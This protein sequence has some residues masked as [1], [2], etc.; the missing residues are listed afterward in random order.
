[1]FLEDIGTV[2]HTVFRQGNSDLMGRV[3]PSSQYCSP[4]SSSLPGRSD[5]HLG[6]PGSR[7][8]DVPLVKLT[9]NTL[10]YT[11]LSTLHLHMCLPFCNNSLR[12][13]CAI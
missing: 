8:R 3:C 1:M 2:C 12:M 7:K 11:I 10:I 13:F 5:M 6:L 4:G 9:M